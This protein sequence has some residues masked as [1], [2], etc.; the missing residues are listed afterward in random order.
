VPNTRKELTQQATAAGFR[1]TDDGNAIRITVAAAAGRGV[2]LLLPHGIW[3]WFITVREADGSEVYDTW[4]EV[5]SGYGQ[6]PDERTAIL[7][8]SAFRLARAVAGAE[9]RVVP[10][11]GTRLLGREWLK[12]RALEIQVGGRWTDCTEV[13]YPPGAVSAQL[14]A[15]RQRAQTGAR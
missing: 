13:L 4:D 6:T 10:P 15:L 14:A 2:E 3:E 9:L 1:V 7:C 11:A 12:S 8:A 5:L